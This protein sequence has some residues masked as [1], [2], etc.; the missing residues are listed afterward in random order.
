MKKKKKQNIIIASIGIVVIA[1]II[2]YYY[3]VDI[4]R[5]KGFEFGNQLQQIQADLKK[6]QEN[7]NSKV[8]I[9]QEGDISKEELLEYGNKHILD[10]E[11]ILQRYDTLSIPESFETSVE[12]FEL[13]TESQKQSDMQFLKW[14]ETNEEEYKIRSNSLLQE[15]FEYELAALEK[16]NAAK[17]GREP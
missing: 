12:L 3:S 8:I 2:S 14:L 16:F 6:S 7:F 1:S 4:T 10:L 13:S 17:Q 15:S 11:A 9:W 5:N